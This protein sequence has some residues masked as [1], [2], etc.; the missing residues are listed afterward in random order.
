MNEKAKNAALRALN[1]IPL[2]YLAMFWTGWTLIVDLAHQSWYYPQMMH[3]SGNLSIWYLILTLLIT[4]ILAI[5][6]RLRRGVE[7][8]RWLMRR[9]KHFGIAC[10]VY[11]AVHTLH[12]IRY[13]GD[14]SLIWLEAL[15]PEYL[16]GWLGL[17]LFLVLA[18]TS[19]R[20]SVRKLGRNWKP[21]HRFVYLA[22]ALTWLHWYLFEF[23][24][25]E[26]IFWAALLLIGRLLP[27]GLRRLIEVVRLQG[28]PLRQI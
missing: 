15:D 23:F 2:L 8:G 9:R 16:V 10:F 18:A 1:S 22:T 17:I 28:R 26:V 3:E 12:Y 11:A 6:N 24:T 7:I 27:T 14:F 13:I 5:I 4:P 20:M 25:A 19:N 21:L